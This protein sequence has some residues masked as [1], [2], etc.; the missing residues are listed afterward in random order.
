MTFKYIKIILNDSILNWTWLPIF[1]FCSVRTRLSQ[2][3][4][5]GWMPNF[6][7]GQ[8]GAKLLPFQIDWGQCGP[9]NIQSF[10]LCLIS[11]LR[12]LSRYDLI[13][14]MNKHLLGLACFSSWPQG[15]S[16]WWPH[17]VEVF[18]STLE[19]SS[20]CELWTSC[21]LF[22]K[23]CSGWSMKRASMGT[24]FTSLA[25]GRSWNW[26]NTLWAI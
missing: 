19:L 9:G 20:S 3:P 4:P 14:D 23:D 22:F 7:K 21:R 24:R 11:P 12:S 2:S 16:L 6:Q 1:S 15:C 8:G 13:A 18:T 25:S 17:T 5:F 10:S 26:Q